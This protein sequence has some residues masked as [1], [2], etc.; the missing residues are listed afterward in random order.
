MTT[1]LKLSSCILEESTVCASTLLGRRPKDTS[2]PQKQGVLN[3]EMEG[4]ALCKV[5][6]YPVGACTQYCA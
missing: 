1:V 3:H 4:D 6:P 5:K 2:H